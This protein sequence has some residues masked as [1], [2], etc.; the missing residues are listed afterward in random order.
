[1]VCFG[2]GDS[3]GRLDESGP[4]GRLQF[5]PERFGRQL[6]SGLM[7]RDGISERGSGVQH[8]RVIDDVLSSVNK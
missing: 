8:G 3:S 4:R 7:D 5:D 6:V 1:M 2:S